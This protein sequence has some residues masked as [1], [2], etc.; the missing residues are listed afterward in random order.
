MVLQHRLGGTHMPLCT[1]ILGFLFLQTW[2]SAKIFQRNYKHWKEGLRKTTVRRMDDY[3]PVSWQV[4]GATITCSHKGVPQGGLCEMMTHHHPTKTPCR[5]MADPGKARATHGWSW[6]LRQSWAWA[7]HGNSP[8]QCPSLRMLRRR[9]GSRMRR[10][11]RCCHLPALHTSFS[12]L[13]SWWRRF[14]HITGKQRKKT[15]WSQGNFSSSWWW[16]GQ[17]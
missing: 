11:S 9:G 10:S 7:L 2:T 12:I 5:G 1:P 6:T 16:A 8:H 3:K 13:R 15:T 14:C 4:A 17:L